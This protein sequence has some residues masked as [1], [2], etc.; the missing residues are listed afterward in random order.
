MRCSLITAFVK[1]ALICWS[2][3]AL[4]SEVLT[5]HMTWHLGGGGVSLELVTRHVITWQLV[6]PFGPA[7]DS[8]QGCELPW[9]LS[10]T[11]YA[12]QFI[13]ALRFRKFPNN[14]GI[15]LEGVP[16]SDNQLFSRW[17]TATAYDWVAVVRWSRSCCQCWCRCWSGCWSRCTISDKLAL[18]IHH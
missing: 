2:S 14:P 5:C 6:V 13:L 7:A 17:S 8:H 1:S 18:T 11:F 9:K 10:Q 15:Y 4:S 16:E 3:R 12:L